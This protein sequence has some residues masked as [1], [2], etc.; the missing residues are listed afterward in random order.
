M[1]G[2]FLYLYFLM[3]PALYKYKTADM[4]C[5]EIKYLHLH[6]HCLYFSHGSQ[7][8]M[9]IGLAKNIEKSFKELF[10][11]GSSSVLL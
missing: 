10:Q 3:V 5:K 9:L 7:R 6:V 11:D 8:G 1:T 2:V 4:I